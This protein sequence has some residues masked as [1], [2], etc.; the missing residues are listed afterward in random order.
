MATLSSTLPSLLTKAVCLQAHVHGHARRA[1][2][3]QPHSDK[4]HVGSLPGRSQSSGG[5]LDPFP[6]RLIV[7][8]RVLQTNSGSTAD[9]TFI[10]I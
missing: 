3:E 7:H 2:D 5:V 10:Y 4:H 9:V 8:A 6:A 1:E